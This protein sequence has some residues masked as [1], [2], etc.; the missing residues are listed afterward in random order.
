MTPINEALDSLQSY[1][2]ELDN[3][4]KEPILSAIIQWARDAFDYD[5]NA[6]LQDLLR[7]LE[8][9]DCSACHAPAGLIYNS[10][11]AGKVPEW[12]Q[13]IDA[14]LDEFHGETGEN[15]KPR[16]AVTVGSLVWFAV[17]WYAQE[18]ASLLRSRFNLD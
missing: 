4:E 12:W 11:I 10:D 6:T 15:W 14:A 9:T 3:R 1:A 13:A 7:H 2:W 17:E 8:T 16:G 5:K 18:L